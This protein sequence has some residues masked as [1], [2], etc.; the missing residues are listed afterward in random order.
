[1]LNGIGD[2][3]AA[4]IGAGIEQPNQAYVYL[5]TTG[6]VARVVATQFPRTPLPIYTL[7]HADPNLLIEIA[8][9]LSAGDAVAW[10]DDFHHKPWPD[11][12][13]KH[14]DVPLFLPYLKGERS[15][16]HDPDVRGAFLGLD[17]SHRP[18]NLRRAVFEGVAL[19]IRHNLG[20]LGKVDGALTVIGGCA[21]DPMWMQILADIT[22]RTI[23]M[24]PNPTSATAYG[25]SL[26]G[27]HWL[28][29]K[30]HPASPS[31]VFSPA[32][33]ATV[34]SARL[35][36]RYLAASDFLRAWAKL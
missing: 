5:G 18:G 24:H 6:W 3:G 36:R 29:W 28:G 16:F 8:P 22:E 26:L 1:V 7:A 20:A 25:A 27:A 19:A 15:P 2:A 32:A 17:R 30:F 13:E 31:V 23:G 11:T 12:E 10:L 9:M 33:E 34:R 21:T 35:F 14:G 4:T